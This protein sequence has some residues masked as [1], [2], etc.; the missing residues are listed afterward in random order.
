MPPPTPTP[1]P[2][3]PIEVL[4]A[5]EKRPAAEPRALL[6]DAGIA[7]GGGEVCE[8]GQDADLPAGGTAPLG[9]WMILMNTAMEDRFK[10]DFNFSL[11]KMME[12]SSL[13]R[14]FLQMGEIS[15][16][17]LVSL[18]YSTFTASDSRWFSV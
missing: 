8:V 16:R 17:S 1:A 18:G 5:A 3:A 14:P 2:G 10:S 13:V 15:S 11:G 9:P 7:I 12:G 6:V 4:P